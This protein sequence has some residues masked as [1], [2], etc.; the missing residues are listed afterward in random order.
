MSNDFLS[1]VSAAAPVPTPGGG[2][3]QSLKDL[4]DPSKINGDSINKGMK[5]GM[6]KISSKL[7]G[8]NA[9]F[10]SPAAAIN[11]FQ[12]LEIPK[13]PNLESMA[14]SLNSLMGELDSTIK[15]LTGI[16]TG[17]NGA[18]TV[19]DILGPLGGTPEIAAAGG[20]PITTVTVMAGPSGEAV[21]ESAEYTDVSGTT[22]GPGTGATFTI[23]ISGGVYSSATVSAGGTGYTVGEQIFIS[24]ESLGG[25]SPDNDLVLQIDAIGSAPLTEA[26]LDAII[27]Q[28]NMCNSL[29]EKALG[30]MSSFT[31]PA[32]D[33]GAIKSFALS[34]H[35]I[36]AS[37]DG[38]A[39]LLKG[40]IPTSSGDPEVLKFGEAIKASLA[41]GKNKALLAANGINPL[42]F[43]D[44]NPFKGLPSA[45]GDNSLNS[46][47]SALLG[48]S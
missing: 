42:S 33:F 2:G 5:A 44:A 13:L 14:P 17:P 4:M 28:A 27:A 38:S 45:P 20:G 1:Q 39:E 47:A 25:F 29:L 41:E 32:N 35:S 9:S 6:D 24:G 16:G 18:P 15:D 21:Q 19:K 26:Q 8:M 48:G 23:V 7:G 37:S 22:E 30:D 10:K 46:G 3:I 11:M 12:K 40:M 43:T 31:P 36:G 34:L